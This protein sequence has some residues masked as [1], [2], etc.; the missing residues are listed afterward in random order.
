MSGRV[1]A[2]EFHAQVYEI[3]R[4]IPRGTVTTYGHI[5]KLAGHPAHSRMVGAALKFLGDP[6]VPWQRVIGANGSISD[7]GDG[8]EG[9][10]RQ[11]EMLREEGVEV[12][13]AQGAGVGTSGRWRVNL[14][15]FGWFPDVVDI[16]Y[17]SGSDPEAE[18]P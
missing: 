17:D 6:T 4:M 16:E 18:D 5:A 2:A 8:G 15:R 3:C 13:E 10:Q 7:R 12:S 1:N 11:A 9:A 14:T